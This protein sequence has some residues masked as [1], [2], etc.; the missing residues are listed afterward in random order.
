MYAIKN[1]PMKI[2]TTKD[3]QVWDKKEFLSQVLGWGNDDSIGEVLAT[4]A[5]RHE[6]QP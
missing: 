6:F 5:R 3:E 2:Q 1:K 4:Q